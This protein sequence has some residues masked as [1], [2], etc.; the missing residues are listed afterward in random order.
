MKF[1]FLIP[2][3]HIII[4]SLIGLLILYVRTII[5]EKAK[6]RELL[7]KN[8]ILTQETEEIKSR[9][10]KEIEEI[11][12]GHQLDI[13]KRKYQYE[14]KKEQY[15]QFFKLLDT[16]S[17]ETNIKMQ[18]QMLPIIDEF[19]RNYLHAA[20]QN[21]KKGETDATTTFSKKI[22]KLMIDSNKEQIRLKIETNTIRVI[23]SDSILQILDSLEYAY[24][25]SFE[26]STKMMKELQV[27][28][29]T[30]DK[31]GMARNQMNMEAIANV[32]QNYKNDLIHQMRIELNEI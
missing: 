11:R 8:K 9:F 14:S 22:Q 31:E 7:N 10:S 21:N 6:I 29:L 18:E 3:I 24:G 20:S 17:S 25:K 5:I 27:Q 32:I 2:Y 15:I 19:N 23:A 12:K 28:M 13:E 16:F 26:E 1:D 30:K 4:Y